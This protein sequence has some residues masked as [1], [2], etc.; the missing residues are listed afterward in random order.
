MLFKQTMPPIEA[1]A[2]V[3]P[4]SISNPSEQGEKS[5]ACN[6]SVTLNQALSVSD[7]SISREVID[8]MARLDFK[9]N[10]AGGTL[11]SFQYEYN[12]YLDEIGCLDP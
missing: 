3:T 7:A 12:D 10:A 6:Q 8:H 1:P 11:I 5:E 9:I 4:P 2:V